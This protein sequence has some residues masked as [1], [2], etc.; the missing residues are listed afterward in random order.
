[1]PQIANQVIIAGNAADQGFSGIPV[2]RTTYANGS[3]ESSS[4]IKEVRR[5][6]IPASAFEVPPGFNRR[7]P[8][9]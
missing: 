9:R 8:E 2:R 1:M 6:A 5:E 4:E 7:T 3:V